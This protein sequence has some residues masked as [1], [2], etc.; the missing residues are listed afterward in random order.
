MKTRDP[1]LKTEQPVVKNFNRPVGVLLSG[2]YHRA[3]AQ[4]LSPK[5]MMVLAEIEIPVSQKLLVSFQISNSDRVVC[6][7][8]NRRRHTSKD[9]KSSAPYWIEFDNLKPS[10]ASAIETFFYR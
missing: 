5:G 1:V 9:A 2:R 6:R 7:A 10:D 8:T 3:K 4:G